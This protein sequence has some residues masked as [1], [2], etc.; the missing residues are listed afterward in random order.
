[1]RVRQ[2]IHN[3]NVKRLRTSM[4]RI[5][6]LPP[7]NLPA[8]FD[9]SHPIDYALALMTP[10]AMQPRSGQIQSSLAIGFRLGDKGT[11]TSRTMM[12]AELT[13][14]LDSVPESATRADYA[15]AIIDSNCLDKATAATRRL[16]NQRIGEL[17]A[18]DPSVALFRVLRRVWSADHAG[19]PLI[20]L[21]VAIA[22]DPIL[23]ASVPP[24]IELKPGE[25]CRKD[26]VTKAIRHVVGDRLNDSILEKVVRNVSSSW[27]QSGHLAGR[28]FKRRLRV[29]P[30]SGA[31]AMALY[32]GFVTGYRGLELMDSPW[33][34]V[35]DATPSQA[36]D[37]ALGAKRIGLIDIRI[38]DRVVDLSLHRLD[39]SGEVE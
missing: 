23:A 16:T 2:V 4:L 14:L 8:R 19:R 11:H 15:S 31:V 29:N 21:L 27:A 25:E 12:L 35:L 10:F 9:G 7:A 3:R 5:D 28:T 17:Y 32:L 33:M 13:A 37:L 38:A 24:V 30:T 34:Q 39:P 26:P 36:T 6:S 1:V 22:R 18:L 20:A